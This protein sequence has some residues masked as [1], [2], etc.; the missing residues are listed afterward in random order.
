M[1]SSPLFIDLSDTQPVM[2]NIHLADILLKRPIGENVK[3]EFMS[4]SPKN[5]CFSIEYWTS[6][7]CIVFASFY[8]IDMS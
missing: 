1:D 7:A 3:S 2:Y 6:S 4:R 5:L 8:D